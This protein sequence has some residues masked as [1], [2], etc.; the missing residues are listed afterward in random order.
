MKD[1]RTHELNNDGTVMMEHFDCLHIRLKQVRVKYKIHAAVE[2]IDQ[3]Q[4][5]MYFILMDV[6]ADICNFNNL[7]QTGV[8]LA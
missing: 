7:T 1:S 8:C 3:N 2:G 6:S 4:Q 5:L